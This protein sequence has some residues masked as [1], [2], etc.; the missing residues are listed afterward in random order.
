MQLISDELDEVKARLDTLHRD[1]EKNQ[2]DELEKDLAGVLQW[3]RDTEVHPPYL[4]T[5]LHQQVLL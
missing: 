4:P 3:I 5:P 2:S 1:M